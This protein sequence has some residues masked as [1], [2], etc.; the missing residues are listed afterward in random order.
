M[1]DLLIGKEILDRAGCKV[2]GD[3]TLEARVAVARYGHALWMLTMVQ[4]MKA[5]SESD[6]DIARQAHMLANKLCRDFRDIIPLSQNAVSVLKNIYFPPTITTTLLPF[7][8]TWQFKRDPYDC[9]LAEKW[10]ASQIDESW[11][12]ISIEKDWTGQ[13]HS[14]HGIAWYS[15]KFMIPK[16]KTDLFE[17]EKGKWVLY[18]GAIDGEADIYMDGQKIGEQKLNPG[19]MWDKALRFHYR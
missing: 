11:Q 12:P 2:R 7:P 8:L 10:Y 17:K 4:N 14:Y 18:F 9:G 5:P 6:K 3:A 13:G 1:N 15:V 19:Y 16:E